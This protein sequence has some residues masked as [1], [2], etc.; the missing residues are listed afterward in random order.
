MAT[1]NPAFT[2]PIAVDIYVTSWTGTTACPRAAN[3]EST[4]CLTVLSRSVNMSGSD[5]SS[6]T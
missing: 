4:M 1:P 3:A 5:S 2:I 6:L